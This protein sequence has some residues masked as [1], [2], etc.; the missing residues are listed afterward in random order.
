[1]PLNTEVWELL[2]WPLLPPRPRLHL[3]PQLH[4][5]APRAFQ[6]QESS[7]KAKLETKWTWFGASPLLCISLFFQS[8]KSPHSSLSNPLP[9][10]AL[11]LHKAPQGLPYSEGSLHSKITSNFSSL[12]YRIFYSTVHCSLLLRTQSGWIHW[13]WGQNGWYN[14]SWEG[15][16]AYHPNDGINGHLGKICLKLLE[17]FLNSAL[18]AD[19]PDWHKIFLIWQGKMLLR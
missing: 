6:G 11:W 5:R 3:R 12:N 2:S 8:S 14:S 15:G 13:Y 1:M 18:S 16:V 4:A 19:F 10:A 9:L 17:F 7:G